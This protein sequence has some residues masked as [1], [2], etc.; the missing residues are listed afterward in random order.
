MSDKQLRAE[1]EVVGF[2]RDLIRIDTSNFGQDHPQTRP[3]LPAVEY[4]AKKLQEVGLQ[5]Q[6]W[7]SRPGRASLAV[8][9][10]GQR[11]DL[12]ALVVHGHLDV[13]PANA[14]DWK[15][16]PFSGDVIDGCVWGR[17][18]VDMKGMDG[19]ILAVIRELMRTNTAPMREIILVFFADEEAG[20]IYGSHWLVDNHPEVFSGATEAISEVGGFSVTV[21]TPAGPQRTYLLQTEEK[22]MRWLRLHA[23]GT[24]GHGSMPNPDNPVS[25][26]AQAV[27]RIGKYDWPQ[28]YSATT[29]ALFE[30]LSGLTD[31]PF[32]PQRPEPLIEAI[33]TVAGFIAGSIR[34]TM[35][36]TMITAGYKTN[37]VPGTATATIDCRFVL[38]HEEALMEKVTELVG[39]NIRVEVLHGD[40]ALEAPLD[41]PFVE[42][43]KRVLLDADPEAVVLPYSLSGGTDNKALST[44][45]IHGYGYAPLR[46]P[47][48]FAFASLF[49]GIDE[50]VPVSALNFG[51][52]VL[53]D[54][55]LS[56]PQ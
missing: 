7:E 9:I 20:G 50:R 42:Q 23:T 32:N 30:G 53:R 12:G 40:V 25:L 13:V 14:A 18:A 15:H 26:I 8:R 46:L 3:E 41:T 52:K 56:A 38:G 29:S 35:N 27:D 28:Q 34:N 19:I 1:D 55:L 43:M 2:V 49:H 6:I 39:P 16:G 31:I 54:F 33:S 47:S 22:G 45:G 36:P 48:D 5:P 37:V 11:P 21:P 4:V 24:A 17:G 44:L 51:V 10:P